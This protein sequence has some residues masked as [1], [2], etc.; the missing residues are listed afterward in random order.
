MTISPR[1]KQTGSGTT[2]GA[3]GQYDRTYIAKVMD[4]TDAQ[5]MGRLRV[6]IAEFGGDPINDENWIAVSYCSPFAGATN[7]WGNL[8]ADILPSDDPAQERYQRSRKPNLGNIRDGKQHNDTQQS[9]GMWFVP[10]DIYNDVVVAFAAG[11]PT[12]GYWFGCIYQQN[13]NHMVPGIAANKS[14]QE[15]ACK[16]Q[17]PPV[18]EYNR[19][20]TNLATADRERRPEFQPL[21]KGLALQGLACDTLRGITTASARREAP[22]EVFGILTPRGNSFVMDDVA[23]GE[24]IRLRTKSGTQ[25]LLSETEG[26]IYMISRDGDSWL[27][28]H[29]D[30]YIDIYAA[31]SISIHSEASINLRADDDVNIEAGKNFNVKAVGGS[32]RIQTAQDL[33]IRNGAAFRHTATG[34]HDVHVGGSSHHMAAGSIQMKSG[35]ETRHTAGGAFHTASGGDYIESAPNIHMN[36]KPASPAGDPDE[37]KVPDIYSLGSNR[38]LKRSSNNRVPE[39][40]P[41][42]PH[43][44]EE[45]PLLP[46]ADPL[47]NPSISGS[48]TG[49]GSGAAT[50]DEDEVQD[51]AED[52]PEAQPGDCLPVAQLR[53]SEQGR[54]MLLSHEA[55]IPY[56]YHDSSGYATIGYGHHKGKTSEQILRQFPDGL[57]E[58]EAFALFGR[59]VAE[60]EKQIRRGITGCMTQQ[61]FDAALSLTYNLG[62]FPQAIKEAINAGKYDQ[63]AALFGRYNTSK[64]KVLSGLVERRRLEATLFS[65]N[66][67]PAA[68]TRDQHKNY[69][70]TQI[71]RRFPRNLELQSG[72]A[73]TSGQ[74]EQASAAYAR[75]TGKTLGAIA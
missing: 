33:D 20:V 50:D 22:S 42:R 28:L 44:I 49:A 25:I 75:M 2:T 63:A 19:L 48:G 17:D 8:A 23:G 31:K 15:S 51:P 4:T 21:N 53:A 30:G 57:T 74:I 64:G 39:H 3:K 52:I 54:L 67:Y 36:T 68:K 7:P 35:G 11:D 59:D 38:K 29:N 55:F 45:S 66:V 5:R 40:E 27:E 26:H 32:G 46:P 69:G 12:K 62:S 61:Q 18:S 47:G 60:F 72:R 14:Y 10:P 16:D 41:W 1:S 9:Y 73:T 58:D 70:I 34:G 24:L 37:A 65:K 71:K 13:M 6:Y 43:S 56:L